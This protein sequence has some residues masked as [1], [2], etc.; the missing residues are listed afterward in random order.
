MY[1]LF[2]QGLRQSRVTAELVGEI[3]ELL[4][5]L[6]YYWLLLDYLLLACFLALFRGQVNRS[7]AKTKRIRKN[8]GNV[9]ASHG[10]KKRYTGKNGSQ[11]IRCFI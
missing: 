6:E 7:L 2:G 9:C 10:G 11:I 5:Y 8:T 4:L 1:E 3:W